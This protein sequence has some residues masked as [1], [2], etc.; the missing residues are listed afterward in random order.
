MK[1][2]NNRAPTGSTAP[3]LVQFVWGGNPQLDQLKGF[4]T[5][6]TVKYTLFRIDGTPVRAE[7]A[8]TI[9]SQADPRDRARTR[10]RMP[11]TAGAS[12]R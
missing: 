3:P 4:I 5:S 2:T 11:P 1:P 8:I 6:S 9:T 12:T 7:V 10:P